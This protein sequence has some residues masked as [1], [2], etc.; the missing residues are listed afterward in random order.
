MEL[1]NNHVRLIGVL[2]F[3]PEVRE[4]AK[5]RMV[6][7]MSVATTETYVQD[8]GERVTDTQ[9]HTVVAWGTTAKQVQQQLRKGTPID[10]EGRIVHRSYERADG[11]K[12]YVT[13]IVMSDFRILTRNNTPHE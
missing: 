8:S 13:E 1:K 10:L 9:W 6:S 7:R 2:G 3:D 11:S 5:G 4:I 12:R